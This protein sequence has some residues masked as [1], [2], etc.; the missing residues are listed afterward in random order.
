MYSNIQNTTYL[1][2]IFLAIRGSRN[3][4]YVSC[5]QETTILENQGRKM[6][7]FRFPRANAAEAFCRSILRYKKCKR[8]GNSFLY[9][10]KKIM[11][12][13][14]S[15]LHGSFSFKQL[16]NIFDIGIQNEN[17]Y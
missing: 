6:A 3:K 10:Y 16:R 14:L 12:Y 2:F 9:D 15:L 11:L 4:Q 1:K 8:C 7:K 17:N 13:F 5:I